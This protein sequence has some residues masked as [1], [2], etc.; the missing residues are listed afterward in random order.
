MRVNFHTSSNVVVSTLALVACAGALAQ[1]PQRTFVAS[2]GDDVNAGVSCRLTAPCR[3]FS[4]AIGQTRPG[5]EVLVLDS[6]GYGPVTITQAVSIIAPAGVYAGVSVFSGDGV[7]VNAGTSDTVVLR[8]LTITGVGGANGVVVNTAGSVDVGRVEISGFSGDGIKFNDGNTLILR[9][10][11]SR[12]NGHNGFTFSPAAGG[13]LIVERSSFD[14]NSNNGGTVTGT[15]SIDT[16]TLASITGSSATGNLASGFV[17]NAAGKLSIQDC[18]VAI[19]SGHGVLRNKCR[20]RG[21]VAAG[22]SLRSIRVPVQFCYGQWR[23][24]PG[25]GQQRTRAGQLRFRLHRLFRRGRL[26]GRALDGGRICHR[27]LR[28]QRRR[29]AGIELDL[30]AELHGLP[31][32]WNVSFAPEQHRQRDN[33]RHDHPA[34]RHVGGHAAPLGAT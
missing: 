18:R 15:S 3:S 31:Q 7:T 33:L 22:G 14:G 25:D 12:Q 5:G 29:N 1:L 30:D 21:H 26:H 17:V 8:G 10:S 4:V 19:L 2:A 32:R 23:N 13:T 24:R 11:I 27:V 28:H 20:R 16:P 34:F 9:D 6:A